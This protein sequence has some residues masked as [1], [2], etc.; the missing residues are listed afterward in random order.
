MRFSRRLRSERVDGSLSPAALVALGTI[1]A[2][3]P[4]TASE[5]AAAERLAPSSTTRLIA[6]LA[7]HGYIERARDAADGRQSILTVTPAGRAVVAAERAHRQQ[8]LEE[9]LDGFTA[10]ERDRLRAAIPLLQRIGGA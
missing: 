5:L 3:E 10:E 9:V 6:T 2:D 1:E 4:L 7:E 8:W